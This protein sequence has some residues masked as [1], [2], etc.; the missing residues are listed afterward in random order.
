[1][2]RRPP[3]STLFPYTT[4]FRSGVGRTASALFC[5]A[6]PSCSAAAPATWS[7]GGFVTVGVTARSASPKAT[8]EAVHAVPRAR[9]LRGKRL[10][11]TEEHTFELQ[12]RQYL[13]CRL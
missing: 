1:M 4:L 9:A 5:N 2:R 6:E 12:S 8:E 11:R 10:S 3:R 7:S 13:V